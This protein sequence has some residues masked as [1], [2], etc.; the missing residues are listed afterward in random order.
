ML[1]K[2]VY[3]LLQEHRER[4]DVQ[5]EPDLR[6]D[7]RGE[8]LGQVAAELGQRQPQ[9]HRYE[10]IGHLSLSLLTIT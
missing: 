9:G 4:G 2:I 6:Q 8:G 10:S 5:P 7:L 3:L 1:F